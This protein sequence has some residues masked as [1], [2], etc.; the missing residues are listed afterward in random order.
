LPSQE[1]YRLNPLAPS[2]HVPRPPLPPQRSTNH[3]DR[4]LCV[5]LIIIITVVLSGWYMNIYRPIPAGLLSLS[6]VVV[7]P[8]LLLHGSAVCLSAVVVLPAVC[9]ARLSVCLYAVVVHLSACRSVLLYMGCFLACLLWLYSC[10]MMARLSVCGCTPVFWFDYRLDPSTV[11][12]PNDQRFHDRINKFW[13]DCWSTSFLFADHVM[14]NK[15]I[16]SAELRG[17]T[18]DEKVW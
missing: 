16:G 15:A 17:T 3:H 13:F 9:M 11:L 18:G 7:L 6:A 4:I 2:A 10:I 5:W 8:V 14:L 12:E 1:P